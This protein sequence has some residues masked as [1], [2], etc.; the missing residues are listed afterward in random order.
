MFESSNRRHFQK[1][2][3]CEAARA[4]RRSSQLS[5]RRKE[6]EAHLQKNFRLSS[7]GCSQLSTNGEK[8]TPTLQELPKYI[9]NIL[10]PIDESLQ[11]HG[12]TGIRFFLCVER[13]HPK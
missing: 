6:R 7:S 12:L 2:L 4:T 1:G 13:S 5:L 8:H 10:Q 11:L 3:D 9:A